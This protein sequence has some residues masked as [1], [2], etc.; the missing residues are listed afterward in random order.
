[1][2]AASASVKSSIKG[3]VKKKNHSLGLEFFLLPSPTDQARA[4]L[5]IHTMCSAPE[6]DAPEVW[7]FSR[8]GFHRLF[9][10]RAV[11]SET[12][13]QNGGQVAQRMTK[14]PKVQLQLHMAGHSGE[15][16]S[17]YTCRI[18]RGVAS[19]I[20]LTVDWQNA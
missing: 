4:V 17:R 7:F 14:S 1:M 18:P 9:A 15:I 6:D 16:V 8:S 12:A 10:T 13:K 5:T 3:G 19:A 2:P 20:N 11:D